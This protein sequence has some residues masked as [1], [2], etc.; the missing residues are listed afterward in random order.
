LGKGGG[1]QGIMPVNEIIEQFLE[2]YAID[3]QA[4]EE[5]AE[6]MRQKCETLCAQHGIKAIISAR[7]K[8][9]ASLRR[10]L[11][12]R[13]EEK[14]YATS[15]DIKF[16]IPDLSGARIALYYPSD[17]KRAAQLIRESLQTYATKTHPEEGDHDDRGGVCHAQNHR[18]LFRHEA[19]GEVRVEIQITSLLMHAWAEIGHDDVYQ[20]RDGPVSH[21][22]LALLKDINALVLV[23]ERLTERYQ[24]LARQRPRNVERP[25][26]DKFDLV[27]FLED[28][29]L[30]D[31]PMHLWNASF[32]RVELLFWLVSE[33]R[34]NTEVA[35]FVETAFRFR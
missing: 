22:E 9:H 34:Y 16:D 8:S 24:Q 4:Y 31:K 5:L 29:I 6:A 23:S 18:L 7:A 17:R 12:N 30:P 19:L 1:N 13:N 33:A 26:R 21:E 25:F 10:K 32:Y 27:E 20:E 15:D 2:Q 14:A 11:Y 28:R 3:H 35:G